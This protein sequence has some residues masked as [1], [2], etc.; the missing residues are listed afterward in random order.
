MCIRDRLNEVFWK[1]EFNGGKRVS[2]AFW[3]PYFRLMK[4]KN[5][6]LDGGTIVGKSVHV[7]ELKLGKATVL[8]D[9]EEVWKARIGCGRPRYLQMYRE[10]A[11]DSS[12]ESPPA[13]GTVII[14]SE[15]DWLIEFTE[16]IVSVLYFLCDS[17]APP[18]PAE[19]FRYCLLYTSPSPRD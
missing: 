12:V 17:N 6:P 4:K 11:S 16:R 18:R 19:L 10:E 5:V 15:D 2:T 13:Y 14:S 8:P 3:L 9:T 1:S 7:K